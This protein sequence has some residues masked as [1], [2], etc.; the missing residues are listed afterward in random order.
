MTEFATIILAGG[1]GQR[2][3]STRPKVLH[4]IAGQPMM[5]YVLAAAQAAGAQ[6]VITVTPPE[7]LTTRHYIDAFMQ[8]SD[9]AHTHATQNAPL[10][11][12]DAVRCALPHIEA[13]IADIGRVVII[14]GDTPLMRPETL[15][16]LANDEAALTILGFEP[17]DAAAYGRI[18]LKDNKPHKI[19]EFKDADTATRKISLCNSGAMAIDSALLHKLLPKLQNDNAQQEFYLTDLLA[20]AVADGQ[21]TN[22]V[23]G[24]ADEVLG[25]DSRQGLARAE[26]LMQ[27]RLRHKLLAAGVTM[28][29]PDSVYVSFDTAIAP[30]VVLEPHIYCGTGVSI[31]TNCTIRAFSHLE[32][33]RIG[34]NVSI[35]PFARLRLGT[36]IA[37]HARIGNF[38]E[39]KQAKIGAGSKVNHLSYIGDATLG[40]DVNIGAGTITCNYDGFN[41][42]QT[43]IGDGAFIGSNSSLIAP[44]AIGQGAYIG[45]GTA[46][47]DDVQADALA[48]T[49]A[50]KREI[51]GWAIKFRQQQKPAT[52]K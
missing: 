17:T 36:Q 9:C 39:T 8:S 16:R 33:V 45:S 3:Q 11:T 32:G 4:E 24:T 27:S 44:I 38:V 47:S 52:D 22:L 30:D 12:G 15:A 37:D 43:T 21:A 46:I 40:R 34:E 49:R 35:G 14:C 10:G 25:V 41:K 13:H 28:Q 42:H 18:I 19:I 1:K 31:G 50:D 7:P 29:D 48:I 5:G 2:M 6:L 26:K 20:L 23:M 51:D